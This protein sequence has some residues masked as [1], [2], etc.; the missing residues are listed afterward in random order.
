MAKGIAGGDGMVGGGAG[1]KTPGDAGATR[2]SRREDRA[3]MGRS[4]AAPVHERARIFELGEGE[5]KPA[6]F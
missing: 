6:P 5:S 2:S 1:Q 4:S 3:D